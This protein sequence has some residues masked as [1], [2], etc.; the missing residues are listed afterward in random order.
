MVRIINL[1]KIASSKKIGFW[2]PILL[3]VL[4]FSVVCVLAFHIKQQN[5]NATLLSVI[6]ANTWLAARIEPDLKLRSSMLESLAQDWDIHGD[7]SLT[8]FEQE[9]Q[10]QFSLLPGFGAFGWLDKN[11]QLHWVFPQAASQEY[12]NLFMALDYKIQLQIALGSGGAR[13]NQSVQVLNI[14]GMA[15]NGLILFRPIFVQAQPV[16]CLLALVQYDV[17]ARYILEERQPEDLRSGV[18]SS[19]AVNGVQVF[20]E[21]GTVYPESGTVY[22]GADTV[23]YSSADALLQPL[24]WAASV[25]GTGKFGASRVLNLLGQR[26]TIQSQVDPIATE[27]ANSVW[28]GLILLRGFLVSVL[29]AIAGVLGSRQYQLNLELEI[30]KHKMIAMELKQAQ[31]SFELAA[32]VDGIGTWRWDM[33]TETT[34]WSDR[35]YTLFDVSPD[36]AVKN[37]TWSSVV[38]PADRG[39]AIVAFDDYIL[40]GGPVF[41][42]E[43]RVVSKS[44][45]I[46]HIAEMAM[47][48]KDSSGRSVGLNGITW[49]ITERKQEQANLD[50]RI[51]DLNCLKRVSRLST[52]LIIETD[53]FYQQVLRLLLDALEFPLVA[54]A[55]VE[56]GGR[57]YQTANFSGEL[58]TKLMADILVNGRNCGQISLYYPL[59][60][61]FQLPGD[62]ILL[63]SI[64]N[65]L[66]IRFG[67]Y[68]TDDLVR[69]L[70]Q[71]AEHSPLSIIITD[72]AG[73]IEYVNPQFSALTGYS[74]AEVLGKNP[75]ILKGGLSNQEQVYK[76]LWATILAG[77][78][79]QGE[80][81]NRKK[82]GEYYWE[83]ANIRPVLDPNGKISHFLAVKENIT[84]L[85]ENE[86]VR[87][88]ALH[89]VG[90]EK[91]RYVDIL[92][93]TGVGT[94]EWNVQSGETIINERWMNILGYRLSDIG[95]VS[96]ET[97][98]EF[99]LAADYQTFN[100]LLQMYFSG[101]LSYF[102]IECRLKHK[103]GS[104]VWV[105]VKGKTISRSD[106]GMPLMFAATFVDISKRKTAELDLH[107]SAARHQALLEAVPDLILHIQKD[108]T[109]LDFQLSSD[110]RVHLQV[111]PVVG[112]S[113]YAIL[114]ESSTDKV[115]VCISQAV[116]SMVMQSLEL[117]LK[118]EDAIHSFEARFRAIKRGEI[119]VI[120]RDVS[121]RNRLEQMKS[122]FINRVTHELRTPIATM[123]LMAN[124]ID[125]HPDPLELEEYW[126]VIKG[127]I[128]R[129][130]MLVDHLLS[131]GQLESD[132][133]NFKFRSMQVEYLIE[134]VVK[135]HRYLAEEKNITLSYESLIEEGQA[136]HLVRADESALMQVFNNLVSNAIKYTPYDGFVKIKVQ[137]VR[138]CIE[139]SI[140]D[141]GMGIS[142]QD[143]PMLFTRFFRGSNAIAQEV[144]G[145][146]IGLFI[147]RS[148][149]DKHAGNIQVSSELGQGSQFDVLLPEIVYSRVVGS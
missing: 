70:S 85:K 46:R 124:L 127:E 31:L 77:E 39:A 132:H 107:T 22:P 50:R 135:Q 139:V 30:K 79:W 58:P 149:L 119:V 36:F 121:E 106:D 111:A 44:G 148:I 144:Q 20:Q 137:S 100:I 96:R 91:Q 102:E 48:E 12:K 3:A 93:S 117:E 38:H 133:Y 47:L 59:E 63:E 62:Q 76:G 103:D 2:G 75:R 74:L 112:G 51:G 110:E 53:D 45:E 136:P 123:L 69:T 97:I 131:A 120:L 40:A 128:A 24:V 138:G 115:Q 88:N 105:V 55:Q 64:A 86:V 145:T 114:A 16:G 27:Q 4:I 116:Q 90:A 122:D 67:A 141:T 99:M 33:L 65:L 92:E 1:S 34:T 125:G 118:L 72:L 101:E 18:F 82:N 7:F 84:A 147:V 23:V 146:G 26:F 13:P 66:G 35:L 43:Y 28:P 9:S 6:D 15:G 57:N 60:I 10:T 87:K 17:W 95:P 21:A 140:I 52:N 37:D 83:R 89:L 98:Q 109:I 32:R 14:S 142:S 134:N 104:L 68:K 126:S 49:D 41:N 73:N 81:R 42:T 8:E 61:N 19:I 11:Q 5:D 56:L 129:E 108:G 78:T 113:I 143:L 94:W 80:F 130:R 25:D 71:S 54:A 29:V